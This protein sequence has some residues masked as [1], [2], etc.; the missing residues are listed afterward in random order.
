VETDHTQFEVTQ[1]DR[2]TQ[3]IRSAHVKVTESGV[4]LYPVRLRYAF[5][6]ELDLMAR[7]AGLRLRARYGGWNREPFDTASPFHVSLYE[8]DSE[9]RSTTEKSSVRKR[10]ARRREK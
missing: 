1:H 9:E 3:S 8:L 10:S 4:H 6:A 2:S 5:P 7:L